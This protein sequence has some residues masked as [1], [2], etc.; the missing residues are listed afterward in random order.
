[1]SLN[2]KYAVST[3]NLDNRFRN[4]LH[5]TNS[6]YIPREKFEYLIKST[7]LLSVAWFSLRNVNRDTEMKG[8]P[9]SSIRHTKILLNAHLKHKSQKLE[10]C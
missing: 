6:S 4:T 10:M 1:L 3:Q 7:N 2:A 8:N 5:Q 9:L